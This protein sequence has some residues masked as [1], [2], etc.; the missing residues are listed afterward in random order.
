MRVTAGI[1]RSRTLSAPPGTLTRPTADRLRESLFNI[2]SAR[3]LD[4]GGFQGLRIADL[5]AGTGAIGIEALSRGAAHCWFAEN[6]PPALKALRANLSGLKISPANASVEERGTASLLTHLAKV[7]AKLDLVYLDPPY[8]AETAYT[9]TLSALGP[10]L[11]PTGLVIAEFATRG[12]QPAER[13]GR[14]Q[15]TRTYKQ[16]ESS[17]A[18]FELDSVPPLHKE[19]S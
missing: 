6:A 19:P 1:Y 9:Q 18:F 7:N 12:F 11:Q 13:Y 15:R 2:L 16:G 8:D 5:Y 10:H 4:R 14:L 3:L 17:L